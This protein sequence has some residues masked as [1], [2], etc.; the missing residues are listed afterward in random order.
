MAAPRPRQPDAPSTKRR[1]QRCPTQRSTRQGRP[2]AATARGRRSDRC[3]GPR[4]EPQRSGSPAI[5]TRHSG[6]GSR[7]DHAGASKD[8]PPAPTS[9]TAR[10]WSPRWAGGPAVSPSYRLN[11]P[12][13]CQR[14]SV[15]PTCG[16]SEWCCGTHTASAVAKAMRCAASSRRPLWRTA[17][18][19]SPSRRAREMTSAD[20]STTTV[21][22]AYAATQSVSANA[23][24]RTSAHT[25]AWC[26][27]PVVRRSR[28]GSSLGSG[29]T[30]HVSAVAVPAWPG[31]TATT[32]GERRWGSTARTRP[33]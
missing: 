24:C 14:S 3:C 28:P 17:I 10:R 31:P 2:S 12:V 4:R 27:G 21:V 9:N 25:G 30:G 18:T 5:T 29:T 1:P 32:T 19:R 26:H 11:A 33:T 15:A 7:R 6:D 23:R 13:K 20:T 22:H 8:V 16:S